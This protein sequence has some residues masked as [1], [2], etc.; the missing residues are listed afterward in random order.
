MLSCSGCP[1]DP[2][3]FPPSARAPS[4]DEVLP[5]STV[6]VAVG[7]VDDEGEEDDGDCKECEG[8]LLL[9]QVFFSNTLATCGIHVGNK[10]IHTHARTHPR[11]RAHTHTHTHN[12]KVNQACWHVSMEPA[13][14]ESW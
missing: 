12:M 9:K 5:L 7:V 3:V 6:L 14:G 13:E 8:G 10:P 4:A 11:P 1:P 2:S